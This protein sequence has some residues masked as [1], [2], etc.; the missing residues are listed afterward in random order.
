M[1]TAVSTKGQVILPKDLRDADSIRPGDKFDIERVARGEYLLRRVE[2][3]PN[4][5]LVD[6]LLD[7]PV[8]DYCEPIPSESTDSL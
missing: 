4:I 7:C 3:V 8:K 2:T 1:K 5:G 6:W